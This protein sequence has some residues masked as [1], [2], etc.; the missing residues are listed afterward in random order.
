VRKQGLFD[1]K[2]TPED[3]YKWLKSFI[4]RFFAN[5]FSGPVCRKGRKLVPSA[6]LRG[7]TGECH[8]TPIPVSGWKTWRPC[9]VSCRNSSRPDGQFR[10]IS[11]I[12]TTS[13]L[14]ASPESQAAPTPAKEETTPTTPM[15]KDPMPFHW[16]ILVVVIVLV[17]IVGM[18]FIR[19][20]F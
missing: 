3:L 13:E 20:R 9:T 17:L 5:Q 16:I 12:G 7:E 14:S 15:V 10:V 8:Q 19:R 11:P 4:R 6:C 1:A 18:V 2:Y